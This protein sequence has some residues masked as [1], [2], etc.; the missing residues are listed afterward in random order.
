MA[1]INRFAI[2]PR[3]LIA[4]LDWGLGHATRCI[5]IIQKLMTAGAE[6]VIAAEGAIAS[7]LHLEFPDIEIIPLTG[8]GIS[9]PGNKKRMQWLLK[10][11]ERIRKIIRY[12]NQWLQEIIKER[13][14]T[15]I[16]SDCRFGLYTDKIPCVFITHQL[17]IETGFSILNLL[18]RKV[19]YSYLN[20]YNVCWVPDNLNDSLAGRLSH[21]N[22]MPGVPVKYIG[23]LSRFVKKEMPL[24]YNYLFLISGPEPQRSMLENKLLTLNREHKKI[25]LVRGL[26]GSQ[27]QDSQDL[28][29]LQDCKSIVIFNHLPA[30]DLNNLIAESEVIISRSGYSTVM[31]MVALEKKA[32]FIPTPGQTEQE[33]LA[34]FLHK[35]NLFQ[36]VEQE[37]ISDV[38]FDLHPKVPIYENKSELKE[39]ICEWLKPIMK[40]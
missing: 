16:I 36:Y 5:P 31:D 17:H 9:W 13:K 14:I 20:K 35:R 30:H 40:H 24:K 8:Y 7:L 6:V 38:V 12:E 15:G 37:N 4:P 33:Y 23:V 22:K 39:T 1:N 2:P 32:V 29:D 18:A 3:I 34:R 21:P 26:P 19:N 10:E 28:Q 27:N 25:A 11:Y